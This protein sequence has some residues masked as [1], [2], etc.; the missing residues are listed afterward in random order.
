VPVGNGAN[1]TVDLNTIPLATIERVEILKDAGSAI[2]GSDA[3]GGVVNIITRSQFNGTEASL[4]TAETERR[5]SFSIGTRFLPGPRSDNRRASIIFSAGMQRQ[6]PV[7]AGDRA[8]SEFD[9]SFNFANGTVV[10]GGSTATPGGRINARAIDVN[11]DGR[12]DTVN[13]CGVNI[14]FCTS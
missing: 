12:P 11:G 6:E 4:Y 2:Y 5:D 13:I 10:N 1:S 9:K 7:F 14:Q 8:F 3:I